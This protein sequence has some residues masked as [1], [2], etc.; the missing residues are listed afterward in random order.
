VSKSESAPLPLKRVRNHTLLIALVVIIASVMAFGLVECWT[1]VVVLHYKSYQPIFMIGMIGPMGVIMGVLALVNLRAARRHIDRPKGKSSSIVPRRPRNW[2]PIE[3]SIVAVGSSTAFL[4]IECYAHLAAGAPP[5]P[6]ALLFAMAGAVG[7]IMV[8]VSYFCL[9][10]ARLYGLRTMS[11]LVRELSSDQ[12]LDAIKRTRGIDRSSIM[13]R[14]RNKRVLES[15]VIIF[16]A[17]TTFGLVDYVSNVVVGDN[18]DYKPVN[19][20]GMIVPMALIMG[21]V[22]YASLKNDSRYTS[23]LL[24]GIEQVA[25]GNFD[26]ALNPASAGPLKEIF[27]NFNIMC[28]ELRSVQTL[29]DDFINHFSHEFKTPITSISGFAE[30]LLKK[31]V[32]EA[33][34][35][36]YLNI[37]AAESNRLSEMA[38]NALM[39]T[40]LE[41]Q[42]YMTGRA[43]YSLDEQ[44]KECI[45][46]LSPQWSGKRLDVT[47][48]LE[49]AVFTG[50]ADLMKHVWINL[51]SNSV[52]FTPEGGKIEVSL[53]G[54]G[55]HL[56]VS[57]SDTGI[58]MTEEELAHAF[59]KY[60][61]G[62][63]SRSSKG[64]GL[65]L[66]IARRIVAL[67]DGKI[68]AESVPRGGSV[69]AVRLPKDW[70]G[71]PSPLPLR[72][73]TGI[74]DPSWP[75]DG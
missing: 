48:D 3:T 59:E 64:I 52:K 41:S 6:L 38:S 19:M 58:G 74:R 60:Y 50:N 34:R 54:E 28:E 2:L 36:L 66:A 13:L 22:S 7:L 73:D 68:E 25:N 70:P 51:L 8:P 17:V 75:K 4:A 40:R 39:M 49:P 63:A 55:D 46:L 56:L 1:N 32:P 31:S 27:S 35:I 42:N 71:A 23:Q 44:I 57:V 33:E 5:Y 47:A 67:C 18:P 16:V 12:S 9:K 45:I 11:D 53:R 30:L 72:L 15:A 43:A 37:I 69:F 21:V 29:R 61:Q 14:L 65:G 24:S 20:I 10:E 26:A 62:G